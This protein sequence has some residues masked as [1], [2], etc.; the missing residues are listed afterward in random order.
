MK[1]TSIITAVAIGFLGSMSLAL[2]DSNQTES[3]NM[4]SGSMMQDD[5]SQGEEGKSNNMMGMM[6]MMSK[7]EPMM[8]QCSEM[9]ETM[10]DHM[11]SEKDA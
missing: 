5:Q 4:K 1:I 10:N 2:A 6:N 9:M 3:Q 11:K 7:M 8:K